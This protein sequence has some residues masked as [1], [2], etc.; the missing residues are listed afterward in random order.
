MKALTLTLICIALSG[1]ASRPREISAEVVEIRKIQERYQTGWW[2]VYTQVTYRFR[3]PD[4]QP[5]EIK[6]I[7]GNDEEALRGLKPGV[8]VKLSSESE[9]EN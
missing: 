4:G 9:N 2:G 3:D 7:Y 5:K 6:R 1:C 8:V